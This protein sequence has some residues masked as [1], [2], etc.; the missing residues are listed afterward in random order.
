MGHATG[1]SRKDDNMRHITHPKVA[2]NSPWLRLVA[3][4][5]ARQAAEICKAVADGDRD[6]A[7]YLRRQLAVQVQD[8]A[9]TIRT[10]K[11]KGDHDYA[12]YLRRLLSED[13]RQRLIVRPPPTKVRCWFVQTIWW[14]R[15]SVQYTRHALSSGEDSDA[16]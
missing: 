2:F 3:E 13:Q 7:R 5:R 9:N 4:I 1:Q 6:Y 15:R 16:Q 10:A 12:R 8:T 14:S 11:A